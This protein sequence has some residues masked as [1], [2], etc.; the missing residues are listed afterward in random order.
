[1]SLRRSTIPW[2]GPGRL[3][4][5]LLA[6]VPAALAYPWPTV[7]DRWVL[8]VALAVLI[9][10]LGWWR[11]LHLTTMLRRRA[12]MFRH[13]GA[14]NQWRSG[15]DVRTTVSLRVVPS[16]ADPLPLPLIA[17]YLDRYG[18]RA[19]TVRI[20][21]RDTGV[22]TTAAARDTW[23]GLTFSAA[24]NLAALQ[25]RSAQIPLRETAEVAARRLADHLRE[26]GWETTTAG[27]DEVPELFAA[28]ARGTWRGLTDETG[29]Y[30]AAYQVAVDDGLPDTLAQ[31][32]AHGA[33]ETWTAVEIG[34]DHHTVAAGCAIRTGDRPAGAGPLP[35]LTPQHG[36]HRAALQA[37]HPL[38]ALRLS[39]HAEL[40]AAVI[41]ALRWPVTTGGSQSSPHARHAVVS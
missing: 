28:T 22:G 16:A 30:V 27:P 23:I 41:A 17:G 2:P 26:V 1:M 40:S 3:T 13:R 31:I 25:A 11:R 7:R 8:G 4:L 33:R 14:R 9:V 18:L 10:L 5:V 29:D 39:G 24:A 20:T 37:L 34:A 21:S 15:P 36:N 6:V 35:G 12:A 38:S 32:W 19:D